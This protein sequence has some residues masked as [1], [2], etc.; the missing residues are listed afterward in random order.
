MRL[1]EKLVVAYFLLGHPV[2]I[3]S[4]SV[5]PAIDRNICANL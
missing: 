1:F 3:G 4:Y 5:M 2:V